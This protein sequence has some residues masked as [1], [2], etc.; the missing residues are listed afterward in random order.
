L[1]AGRADANEGDDRGAGAGD[2]FPGGANNREEKM[3]HVISKNELP[4]SGSAHKF[5]GFQ[6]GGADVS[7]FISD[8]PPGKGPGLHTHP[9]AEV[10]V[11]QEGELTFTVGETTVGATGGQIVVVP[12]GTPHKFVNSG[13]RRARHMDIH[14]R[15]RMSTE[16]LEES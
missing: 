4:H 7:F 15:G 8:T 16:W 5:E 3:A 10:F 1:A 2:P 6:Y 14:T 11:V 12:A 9:Y 13:A